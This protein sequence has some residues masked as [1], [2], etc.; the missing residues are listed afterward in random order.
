MTRFTRAIDALQPATPA[1]GPLAEKD[2]KRSTRRAF[3]A[4][5]KANTGPFAGARADPAAA[6]SHDL[7]TPITRHEAKSRDGRPTGTPR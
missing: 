3:N 5:A 1:A 7:Q 4:D 6:I 2:H